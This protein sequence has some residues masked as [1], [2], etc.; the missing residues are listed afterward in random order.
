MSGDIIETYRFLRG[1]D[2]VNVERMFSLVGE[3]RIRRDSLKIRG[4]PFKAGTKRNVFFEE[5]WS[6]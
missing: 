3:T 2:R 4:L 1:T 5:H 6:V